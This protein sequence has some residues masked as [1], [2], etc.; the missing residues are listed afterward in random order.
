M[1]TMINAAAI[2]V[3]RR[4]WLMLMILFIGFGSG[5]NVRA[6]QVPQEVQ[7]E[8]QRR[9]MTVEEALEEAE[10]LGVDTSSPEVMERTAREL[11]FSEGLIEELRR[12]ME[13]RESQPSPFSRNI[14]NLE[15][16]A[17]SALTEED[18]L[19]MVD[20][21]AAERK[22]EKL[23][24]RRR[25][26]NPYADLIHE[27]TELEYF[28][29]RTFRVAEDTGLD[30]PV[31]LQPAS[32]AYVVGPGDEL[33]LSVYGSA[34][35]TH[36]L[37]VDR[38]GRVNVPNVGLLTVAGTTLGDLQDRFDRFLSSRYAGIFSVPQTVFVDV[39]VTRLRPVRVF[40][41]GEVERPGSYIMD[42]GGG[43]F[44]LLYKVGGPTIRGSLRNI[45]VSRAGRIIATVDA[46]D[47]LVE[48]R[49]PISLSLQSGDQILVPIRAST[50]FVDGAVNRPGIY[51]ILP[52][53]G[54]ED[55]LRY[56][57][58]L[59]P[60]AYVGRFQVER[61]IPFVERRDPTISREVVDHDLRAVLNGMSGYRLADGD[62]VEIYSISDVDEATRRG[63]L[64][65]VVVDGAVF[66][67]GRYELGEGLQTVRDLVEF[68]DGLT[69]DAHRP[70]ANLVRNRPNL[71]REMVSLDLDRVLQ[72]DPTQNL[73]LT[74]GDSLYVY[75][76]RE[77]EQERQVTIEG[78]ILNPGEYQ[79]FDGMT[80]YDLLFQAG[81]LQDE[82]FRAGVFLQRAD[83]YRR[84]D[85]GTTQ[86]I[87]FD[88]EQVMMGS[89][90]GRIQLE[91]ND[92]VRIYPAEVEVIRDL[93]VEVSGAVKE[94]GR[95]PLGDG[96]TVQDLILQA[97]GF[98]EG[99]FIES[100][101]VT[102]MDTSGDMEQRAQTI[103]V[104]LTGSVLID[105]T[106]YPGGAEVLTSQTFEMHHRDRLYVR[107]DPAFRPQQEVTIRGEVRFPGTYTLERENERL[108]ELIS[109]A[110]G[111]TPRAY[112]RG[113][114]MTRGEQQ[115]IVEI[116]KALDGN[117]RADVPMLPGDEI[118]IPF[119]PNTVAVRGAVANDGLIQ[120]VE[121]RRVSYYLDRAGG[122]SDSAKDIFVTQASGAVFK[123]R[124]G[125]FSQNP[126]VDDGGVIYVSEQPEEDESG[127]SLGD[128]LRESLTILA[129]AATIIVPI[130][131]A[132]IQ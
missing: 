24:E 39:S 62:R 82:E 106:R 1:A 91:S 34:E 84:K 78:Q 15:A 63:L 99:A 67:P 64:N 55:L 45:Q 88:L 89:E 73:P 17:D 11:G 29:Y 76:E 14:F 59:L 107:T 54:F 114:V 18:S 93:F 103:D 5:T 94:P 101:E 6:Q 119:R 80:L 25:G 115:L 32:D 16:A 36:D 86:L 109:R 83:L 105:E 61:I 38:G 13:E 77:F 2:V 121:G 46:Y 126:V 74:P 53:E 19:L 92:S 120:Y 71:R 48:G 52:D 40:V 65:A 31:E 20:S 124:Q 37:T 113:G 116:D 35:F 27:A 95:Y 9:G 49:E 100:V 79:L 129:S 85:D 42:G 50:V 43:V 68:A 60:E 117:V 44:N 127:T 10:R 7:E 30:E 112:A 104:P 98:V 51:E 131:V 26:R 75:S 102:R 96:M 130:V 3:R 56:A 47:Y 128:N 123:L 58:N 41:T 118:L 33:R 66:Q 90:D 132:L 81:G 8:L 111:L 22:R 87:A 4:P 21:L 12:L 125:L 23:E 57:G 122:V 97:G 72:D 108:S 70:H 69:G 110:G 28:G